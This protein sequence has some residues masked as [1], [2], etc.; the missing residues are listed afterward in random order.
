MVGAGVAGA[1]LGVAAVVEQADTT[2]A[3]AATERRRVLR[4]I[5]WFLPGR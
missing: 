5:V 4:F 1:G 3:T 2:R